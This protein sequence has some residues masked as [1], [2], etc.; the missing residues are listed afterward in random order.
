MGFHRKQNTKS[1]RQRGSVHFLWCILKATKVF[2]MYVWDFKKKKRK[3]KED[4]IS[5]FSKKER[6]ERP[7]LFVRKTTQGNVYV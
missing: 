3:E 5:V 4:D 1:K 2:G 7:K 6:K